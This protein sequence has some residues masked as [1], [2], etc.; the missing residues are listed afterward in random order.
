VARLDQVLD[1]T[2]SAA[3]LGIAAQSDTRN[4][5]IEL[6]AAQSDLHLEPLSVT[7]GEQS[8]VTVF[9][10][11]IAGNAVILPAVELNWHRTDDGLTWHLDTATFCRLASGVGITGCSP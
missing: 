6:A 8:A 2:V 10:V 7:I 11:L 5:L 4:E 9:D 1:P 3:D